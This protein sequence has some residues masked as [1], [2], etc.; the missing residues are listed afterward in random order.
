MQR[1]LRR[2]VFS[3][4]LP[5]RCCLFSGRPGISRRRNLLCPTRVDS[6]PTGRDVKVR[7]C[8]AGAIV[9]RR[10]FNSVPMRS[11]VVAIARYRWHV[12]E[13]SDATTRQSVGLAH[14]CV[15]LP[16]LADREMETRPIQGRATRHRGTIHR[17]GNGWPTRDSARGRLG[18]RIQSAKVSSRR[19]APLR[20]ER[21]R[22]AGVMSRDLPFGRRLSDRDRPAVPT[23]CGQSGRFWLTIMALAPGGNPS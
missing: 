17:V 3:L 22:W 21:A 13:Y 5:V 10:A 16:R 11:S 4:P 2:G 7:H 6:P 9:R 19:R 18:R 8:V 14:V 1:Q 15:S 12:A 20:A 23:V